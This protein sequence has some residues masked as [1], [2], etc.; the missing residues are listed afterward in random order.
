M[1][2][3]SLSQDEQDLFRR[4]F[5]AVKEATQHMVSHTMALHRASERELEVR[6]RDG[7][8]GFRVFIR[9]VTY[10]KRYPRIGQ[11]HEVRDVDGYQI[12]VEHKVATSRREPAHMDEYE[13]DALPTLP[14]VARTLA[15][16]PVDLHAGNV[17]ESAVRRPPGDAV[18]PPAEA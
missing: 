1:S 7:D 9:P 16:L 14:A 17:M 6:F 5:A 10:S 4:V 12:A 8:A 18:Q 15:S 11:D 13:Y 3:E 2:H